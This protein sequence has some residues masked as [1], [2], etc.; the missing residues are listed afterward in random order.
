MKKEYIRNKIKFVRYGDLSSIKHKKYVKNKINNKVKDYEEWDG[1]I[2]FHS[3]PCK[4]G[5]YAFV[6]PYVEKFLLSSPSCSGVESSHPKLT[7]VRD[8]KGDKI[9]IDYS[10]ENKEEG[11]EVAEYIHST[12]FLD[13]EQIPIFK[14]KINKQGNL[15]KDYMLSKTKDD[16]Y[17]LT[18]RIKPKIFEYKKDIWHHLDRYLDS[19]GAVLERKGGWVKTSFLDYKIALHKYLGK[20]NLNNRKT[21]RYDWDCLEV[22]IEKV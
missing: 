9:F 16:K 22:F 1:E 20:V 17:V 4:R 12:I 5:I 14:S 19:P 18:K 7:Y 8:Q 21:W 11:F 10:L 6:Y 15:K 2:G 3:P 13:Q